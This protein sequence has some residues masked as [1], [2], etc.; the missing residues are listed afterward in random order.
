[1]AHCSGTGSELVQMRT[2]V[3]NQL[4][5]MAMNE[6]VRQK[7][8]SQARREQLESLSLQEARRP[9]VQQLMTHPGV[10]PITALA[11]WLI[12]GLAERF[13]CGK[14]LSSYLGLI[15]REDSSV[16]RQRLGHISKQGNTPLRFLLV[17]AAQAM[18]DT[19]RSGEVASCT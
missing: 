16:D 3:M 5:A 11:F 6:G 2:R 13:R 19:I 9:E 18:A 14:Q 10:G 4:Q 17:E 12:V 7:G 8:L 15:P 1:M